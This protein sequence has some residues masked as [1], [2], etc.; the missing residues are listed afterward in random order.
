MQRTY[1]RVSERMDS[2]RRD[3]GD[4]GGRCAV[5]LM[6]GGGKELG[7]G[8]TGLGGVGIGGGGSRGV[9]GEEARGGVVGVE[10]AGH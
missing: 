1:I 10:V 9:A 8:W 3:S 7:G 2:G 5:R 4:E 6:E